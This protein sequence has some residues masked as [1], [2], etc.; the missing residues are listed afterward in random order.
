MSGVCDSSVRKCSL[1]FAHVWRTILKR[2]CELTDPFARYISR[3][4]ST[5]IENDGGGTRAFAYQAERAGLTL[6]YHRVERERGGGE[7]DCA[8]HASRYVS[9]ARARTVNLHT[10]DGRSN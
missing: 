3:D 6:V 7:G 5:S 9:Y 8:L 4:D 1:R 10:R 2:R